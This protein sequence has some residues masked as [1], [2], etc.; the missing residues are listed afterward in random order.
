M[1]PARRLQ[2]ETSKERH[3]ARLAIQSGREKGGQSEE[4][5][6]RSLQGETSSKKPPRRSLH[7]EDL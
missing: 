1:T 3:P 6:L 7:R 4:R 5:S 2:G